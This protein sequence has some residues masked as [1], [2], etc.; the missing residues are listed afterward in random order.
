M[1]PII[2]LILVGSGFCRGEEGFTEL[3]RA[4]SERPTNA[5]ISPLTEEDQEQSNVYEFYVRTRSN[6]DLFRGDSRW[7]TWSGNEDLR[8]ETR[9][10]AVGFGENGALFFLQGVLKAHATD[11]WQTDSY[12]QLHVYFSDSKGFIYRVQPLNNTR[13]EPFNLGS[14]RYRQLLERFD[15]Y[16]LNRMAPGFSPS[17]ELLESDPEILTH[18]LEVERAPNPRDRSSQGFRRVE[19][20]LVYRIQADGKLRIEEVQR[21]SASAAAGIRNGDRLSGLK[22]NGEELDPST[23]QLHL[24]DPQKVMF[25]FQVLRWRQIGTTRFP[26]FEWLNVYRPSAV[27]YCVLHR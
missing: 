1:K 8:E 17:Y 14:E 10:L 25:S 2:L 7:I 12:E 24:Q 26:S 6:L 19:L 3:P 5:S 23:L 11:P 27:E 22:V 13:S 20:G 21:G 9:H 15:D 4:T 18:A 16:S